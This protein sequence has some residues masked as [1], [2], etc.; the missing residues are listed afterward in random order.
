MPYAFGVD[1]G[2]S[3]SRAVLTTLQGE[4]LHVARGAG[5]N[6]HEVSASTT[7]TRLA[8][9]F[10]QSLDASRA[11]PEEC[12]GLCFGLAGAGREQDRNILVP[13]L[14]NL[15][16]KGKY[17]L[18]SDAEIALSS[19]TLSDSGILV[20]AGTGSMIFACTEAGLTGRVGG[21][22]PLLSDEGSGYHIGLD[23]LKAVIQ[24]GDGFDHPTPLTSP[25]L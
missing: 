16:G 22:G 4:V 23:A 5:V 8:N 9:L 25:F 3:S 13:L 2:A 17:L 20:L 18:R 24:H 1:G 14:D 6:Y 21:Y 11:R 7:I 12:Q 15:F 10:H 19:G